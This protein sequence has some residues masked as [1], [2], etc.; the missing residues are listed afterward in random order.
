[1][2]FRLPLDSIAD[3]FVLFSIP[4][5]SILR[6]EMFKEEYVIHSSTLEKNCNHLTLAKVTKNPK[7]FTG[8]HDGTE[9]E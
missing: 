3:K 1:M 8:F 6:F 2:R 5:C 7:F 9:Q 4:V